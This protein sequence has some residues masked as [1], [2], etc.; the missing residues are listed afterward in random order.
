MTDSAAIIVSQPR[1]PRWRRPLRR[2]WRGMVCALAIVGFVTLVRPS[3]FDLTPMISGSMSPTLQGDSHS[4]DWVLAEKL[5]YLFRNPRRWEIVEF[6]DQD[7]LKIMKRVAA[8]PG[9]TVAIQDHRIQVDGQF[10]PPPAGS[11]FVKY[12]A[13]GNA[14]GGRSHLVGDGYYVLGDDSAD[15]Q[16]S[17]FDGS[18]TMNRIRARAWLIV[19]PPSRIGWVR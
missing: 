10:L 18:V 7:G 13:Y 11:A 14:A 6:H 3:V 5:T 15:S 4:G 9:E 8:L 17:R 16:D 2:L 19:W 12:L 1:P